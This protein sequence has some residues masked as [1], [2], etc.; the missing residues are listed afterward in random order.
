MSLAAVLAGL[1][2]CGDDGPRGAAIGATP[3]PGGAG[4][5]AWALPQRPVRLDPLY[6]R[7]PAEQLV[8]RQIN[9]PL[10]AQLT[11]PY[12]D[13]RQVNGLALSVLPSSDAR[14]WRLRLRS[15]VSFG[16]GAPFNAAAVLAN[17]ERWRA[18]PAARALIGDALVDAPTPD[19]VRFILPVPDAHFDRRLA[20][21]LLGI[22]SPR[23]L[24]AAGGAELAPAEAADSGT[25]PFELRERAPDR[26]LLARNTEW[27]GSDRG[28]GP[29][30]D[31]LEF[32]IVAG[33]RERLAQLREGAVQVASE[34]P[35]R[36]LTRARRDPLLSVIDEGA[37]GL[38]IERSV[39]GI[40]PRDPAPPLNGVWRTAISAD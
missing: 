17:V 7:T 25:G 8:S 18:N 11:G 15:G 38:A 24:A 37:T 32:A 14:V 27:W 1:A 22:V 2:G 40:P 29:G 28:L 21:P 3:P 26:L 19:L 20:S 5:I 34:L 9:E 23:A 36:L 33:A 16:D 4:A 30:V 13:V 6:A 35:L 31:Q 39:R 10:V 12:D